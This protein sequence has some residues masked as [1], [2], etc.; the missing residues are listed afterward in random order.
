VAILEALLHLAVRI[1]AQLVAEGVEHPKQVATLRRYGVGV[2]QGNLLAPPSRRPSTYLAMS[3]IPEC[4]ALISPAPTR[5]PPGTRITDF[6]H[7]AVTL[8]L[9]ATGEEVRTI[10]ND[11]P[12]ISGVVLLDAD[13][14]PRC[15]LDRNRFLLAV[16]GAYGYALYAQREAARL[17]DEPRVLQSCLSVLAALELVRSSAAHRRYDDIIVLDSDGRCIGTVCVGDVIQGVAQMNL[18]LATERKTSERSTAD[19]AS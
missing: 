4:E 7:P 12:T 10:L 1:G 9:S 19:Q 3:K 2:A 5:T 18:D 16:S 17:G 14:K 15:T 11:R 6:M 13:G 8:P